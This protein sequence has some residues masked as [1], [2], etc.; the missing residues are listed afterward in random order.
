MI[1]GPRFSSKAESRWFTEMGWQT[2]TM[3]QYPEVI[4]AREL[5]LCYVNIA[6]VT[7][8][9]AGLVAGEAPVEAHD[10]LDTSGPEHGQCQEGHQDH[11]GT[12]AGHP[13]RPLPERP[14]DSREW[15]N[16]MKAL[17]LAAGRGTRLAPLTDA[18]PKP[19]LPIAGVPMVERIMAGIAGGRHPRVCPGDRL[20]GRCRPGAISATAR[21]G[22]GRSS[23]SIRKCRAGWGMPSHCASGPL[24]DAPFLMTYGDI[25]LDPANYAKFCQNELPRRPDFGRP[26]LGGRPLP[27]AAVYLDADNVD[28]AHR[29]KAAAGARRRRIGTMPGCSSS[30]R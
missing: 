9:D 5:A 27:G 22:A 30:T 17:I 15:S 14:Q 1:Q 4:L 16:S 24:A 8:Y 28:R 11:A 25:M 29:G 6:L 10:V 19:M 18:C 26:E 7:D 13:R 3:T 2:V 21:A 20:P 23:M 12:H